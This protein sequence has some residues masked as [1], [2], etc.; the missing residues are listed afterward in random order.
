MIGK[1][2]AV[3][4]SSAGM[5]YL[6]QDK[7]EQ[8]KERG[9]ELDRNMILGER[10]SEIMSELKQWNADN[11]RELKNEVFSMV[12]SPAGADGKRLTDEQLRELGKEFMAKT[13]GIDP[14]TQPYYMRVHEDTKNK[15]VHIY[16][17]R[18]D[19]N[20]K[21]ISDRHCQYRAMNTA[22]ELAKKHD[23]TR[24]KEIMQH[25]VENTKEVKEML[26]KEVNQVLDRSTSWSDFKARASEKGIGI[27]ET[28]NRQG[29]IQGYRI[30]LGKLS[31]K[32]SEIDRKITLPKLEEIF[33]QNT[34]DIAKV[35]TRSKDRGISR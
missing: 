32:A 11:G 31:F 8:S 3:G 21:T 13:L 34:L 5:E 27:K 7:L 26:K 19:A 17:S 10:P 30:E 23:L 33:K 25:R 29:A 9:Y 14:Y 22:D 18:T 20:G 12:Y 35:L 4:G 6:F 28:V 15:H 2:K 1:C 24:A 16:T